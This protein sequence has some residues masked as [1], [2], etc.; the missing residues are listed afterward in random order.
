M[1]PRIL[2]AL[3]FVVTLLSPA[4]LLADTVSDAIAAAGSAYEAGDYN[5][6]S[7]QLITA[8]KELAALQSTL[9][10][11][12]FP[13]APEGW[14]RTDDAS[15]AEGL[16]MFG[17]GVGAQASYADAEG[18]SVTLTAFADN[19]MVQSMA[20]MLSNPATMAMMGKVQDINGTAFM[21][22]EG[23]YSAL[24]NNR[25][26]V[27][28]QGGTPEMAQQILGATDLAALGMFDKP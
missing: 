13:P 2:R 10:F 28:T 22:Q 14:T 4:P 15:V 3:P 1:T 18:N 17:G 21:D 27:Q 12:K 26:L 25:V 7:A 8:G 16:A 20:A 19:M 24:L 23:A 5:G 9:M 6:A 11:A